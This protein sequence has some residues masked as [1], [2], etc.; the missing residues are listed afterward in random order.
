MAGVTSTGW[1]GKTFSELVD[2]LAEEAKSEFG[3]DFPTTPDSVFGSL[4]NVFAASSKDLWDLG[5][6]LADAQNRDAA[7]GVYLDYLAAL[8]GLSR[9]TDSGSSGD[10]LFTGNQAATVAALFPVKDNLNRIVLT[11]EVL[12]LNRSACY[13]ST[14]SVA[15]LNPSEDYT[16]V[17]EGNT[18]TFTSDTDPTKS[19]ILTGLESAMSAAT[20]FTAT[21]VGETLVITLN[22]F[23][24]TLTTTNTVNLT[25][26]SVGSLVNATAATT[27]DLTFLADTLTKLGSSSLDIDSVTNPQA[28]SLGRDEETDEELRLRMSQREQSTGTATKPAIEAS[29]SEV[30][31]VT[32]VLVNENITMTTDANGVPPKA[33][34]TFV[35]GGD[36]DDIAE[37]LW[38][39]KPAG[40]ETFGDTSKVV[41]DS[42]GDSQT[43]YFSRKTDQYAWI[44]VT[45][46]IN[47]E[48][49]FPSTGEE[50][51]KTAVVDKGEAMYSGED[52]EPT[53]FYAPI[54]SNVAGVYVTNL[55]IAITALPTDTPTYGT[56]RLSVA[57]TEDLNFDTD[58]V[59]VTT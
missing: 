26:D 6:A 8:I 42:N 46:E 3:E 15:A 24:N 17:A 32:S 16:I 14:F 19:E 25:L 20:E 59:I 45:Y 31:G 34:E 5:Q 13:E 54:Y 1:V 12:E 41:V 51:I 56:T 37:V 50:D 21:V 9:L 22:S 43:V 36:E 39:T 35:V 53:K 48:E 7:E 47:S 44:R 49:D 52:F 27:G 30:E 23:N 57:E 33:Y 10:L 18:Y 40:I 29:L 11:D 38:E 58:R 55:E 4:T 28:F 2:E